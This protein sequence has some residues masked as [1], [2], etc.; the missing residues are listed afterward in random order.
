MNINWLWDVKTSES[1][2]KKILHDPES[3]Y[4]ISMA[5]LLLSRRNDPKE[6]FK[7]YLN[8]LAFCKKWP[9][10]MRKM[11]QDKWNDPRI[12]F[13][14]AIYEKL[15]DRYRGRGVSFRE[16][17]AP[18]KEPICRELGKML[19]AIR[20]KQG[21]SQKEV[22]KKIGVSQQVISRIEKGGEN[23]SLITLANIA[24]ALN[25][26]VDIQFTIKL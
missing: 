12:V 2:A 7:N 11:R 9:L 16:K 20:R 25:R 8:P 4:F 26:K 21:L 10:I 13:W 6:V 17:T 18:P 15:S 5:A 1:A 23:A 3:K 24:R 19:T 14:K 22:A